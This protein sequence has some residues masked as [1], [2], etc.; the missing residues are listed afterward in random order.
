[1]DGYLAYLNNAIKKFN[2]NNYTFKNIFLSAIAAGVFIALGACG[3]Q[4]TM[5]YTGNKFLSA[6]IFAI[7]LVMVVFSNSELFTGN[8]L[9]IIPTV[10]K[11]IKPKQLIEHGVIVFFGNMVGAFLI[12]S[13]IGRAVPLND[14]MIDTA[15]AKIAIPFG[16]AL[17]LGILCN[18]LVCMA[19]YMAAGA[20]S[21]ISKIV[22]LMLPVMLFVICGFEHSVANMYFIPAAADM[23]FLLGNLILVTIGNI[24]GGFILGIYFWL[25]F[26]VK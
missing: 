2:D 18:I 23:T 16:R 14:A 1:M 6:F 9:L 15:A 22:L 21:S 25:R 11:D 5:Y 3:S 26:D 10:R 20:D 12:A 19:V 4:C 17:V 7:G 8:C 24:I 13:T